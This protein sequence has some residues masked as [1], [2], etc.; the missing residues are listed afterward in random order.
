MSRIRKVEMDSQEI[1]KKIA[2]IE[3]E[4]D[5]ITRKA[6]ELR[7]QKK[8]L[9]KD[10]IVAEKK[11]AAIKEEEIMKDL[12]QMIKE[13]GLTV[14]QVRDILKGPEPVKDAKTEKW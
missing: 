10:L 1:T 7:K 4:I 11:E 12:A 5:S 13:K 2:T 9:K 3:K 6:K 14:E 8:E